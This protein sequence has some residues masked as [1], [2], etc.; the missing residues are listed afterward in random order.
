MDDGLHLGQSLFI[1][2]LLVSALGTL[3]EDRPSTSGGVSGKGEGKFLLRLLWPESQSEQKVT[4]CLIFKNA[5]TRF[6]TT[7][8]LNYAFEA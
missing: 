3:K 4:L 7:C 2:Q 6:L 1:S 8:L 5:P